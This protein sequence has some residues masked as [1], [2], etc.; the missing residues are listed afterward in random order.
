MSNKC[1]AWLRLQ[2]GSERDGGTT[3]TPLLPDPPDPD[4]MRTLGLRDGE[5][6]VIEVS[7]VWWRVHRTV[8]SHVLKWNEFRSWAADLEVRPASA[9]GGGGS[10]PT[11]LV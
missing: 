7:D 3:C 2:N 4:A 5:T 11:G 9:S 1:Y 8:G 10:R 6:R